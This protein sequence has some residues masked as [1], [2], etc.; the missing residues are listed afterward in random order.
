MGRP[1]ERY[2]PTP[3]PDIPDSDLSQDLDTGQS[4]LESCPGLGVRAGRFFSNTATALIA[5]ALVPLIWRF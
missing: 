5:I 4:L 2:R 3:E 1:L